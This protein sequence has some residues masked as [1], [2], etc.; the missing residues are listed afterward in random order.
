MPTA[1]VSN[2]LQRWYLARAQA[3]YD[4]L[5]PDAR[6]Q[7][8]AID[9]F[10]VSRQ[11]ALAWVALACAMVGVAAS[12]HWAGFAPWLAAL[13]TLLF[14][15]GLAKAGR[16]AWL[17]PELFNGRRLWRMAWMMMAASYAGALASLIGVHR[18]R[19]AA[20]D[21]ERLLQLVWR[22]TPL[23][24]V[25]GLG[26]LLTLW[27]TASARR[28]QGQRDLAR[29]QLVQERDAA[30]RQASEAQLRLLRAQIQPHF[31]FNTLSAVQH[32]VDIHDDRASDLLRQLTAFLRGSTELLSQPEVSLKQEA[33]LVRH[34]LA[35]MQARLADRLQFELALDPDT[36]AQPLPSGLLITLAENAV[37]HGVAPALQGGCVRIASCWRN[38]AFELT[39]HNTGAALAPDWREGVGLANSRERLRHQFGQRATLQLLPADTG[40]VARLRVELG[41]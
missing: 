21:A 15:A 23:Q 25:V 1:P 27:I 4:R 37:E 17:E 40:T 31:I 26:V 32:W 14:F 35:I 24:L 18:D 34:Y 16:R 10:L 33:E 12:L 3:G 22:A 9:R 28:A 39:V 6:A 5:A 29:M 20:W 38:D 41:A 30:A 13:V 2:P 19:S 36:L 8:E 7:A 11:G